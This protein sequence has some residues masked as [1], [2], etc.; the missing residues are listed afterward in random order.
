MI[1]TNYNEVGDCVGT[2]EINDTA[3]PYIIEALRTYQKANR[4]HND[5]EAAL[6]EQAEEA[7]GM[8]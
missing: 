1:I 2:Q 3:I 6:F 5:S 7:L 4:I 8:L